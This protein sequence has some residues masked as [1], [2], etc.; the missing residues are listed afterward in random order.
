ME[1]YHISQTNLITPSA[2]SQ[3]NYIYAWYQKVKTR[4][5]I[6][7]KL[8]AVVN[9]SNDIQDENNKLQEMKDAWRPMRELINQR[10][11]IGD[12]CSQQYRAIKE[13]EQAEMVFPKERNN[14]FFYFKDKPIYWP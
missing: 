8:K 13:L 9:L 4:S 12:L 5:E 14:R 7:R 6:K 3:H 11:L 2:P 1:I 10:M